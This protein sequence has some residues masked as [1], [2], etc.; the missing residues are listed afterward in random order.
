MERTPATWKPFTA[1][2]A[3]AG[4]LFGSSCHQVHEAR[5][6]N[7]T[8]SAIESYFDGELDRAL[9][10]SAIALDLGSDDPTLRRIRGMIFMVQRLPGEALV[11]LDAGLVQI[12][13]IND[14]PHHPRGSIGDDE[15]SVFEFLRGSALQAQGKIPE[16]RDAFTEAVTLNPDNAG[17]QNNLSWLLATSISESNRDGAL[18]ILH[19]TTACELTEWNDP[20]TLDT[21]AAACAEAGDFE[22]AVKWQTKAIEIFEAGAGEVPEDA[23]AEFRGR[24]DLYQGGNPHREDPVAAFEERGEEEIDDPDLGA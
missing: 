24:L 3:L 7:L 15:R 16:S 12:Q 23:V 8:R 20:G 6:R 11:E 17:A 4:L 1:A 10:H 21:L 18:A 19:G 14:D 13:K 5:A 22:N 2:M 9:E